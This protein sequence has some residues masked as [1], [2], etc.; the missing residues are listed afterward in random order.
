MRPDLDVRTQGTEVVGASWGRDGGG[1][2]S[3][4]SSSVWLVLVCPVLVTFYGVYQGWEWVERGDQSTEHL[5]TGRVTP[6][7]SESTKGRFRGSSVLVL[8]EVR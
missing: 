4:E 6:D 3:R 5:R 1:L 8:D 7:P 2:W